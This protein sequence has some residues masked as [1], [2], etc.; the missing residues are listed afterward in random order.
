MEMF[1]EHSREEVHRVLL[2]CKGN[3]DS[4]T[5]MLLDNLGP[6]SG[7]Q[8]TSQERDCMEVCGTLVQ[9]TSK[10]IPN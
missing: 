9:Y 3:L 6:H 2:M 10:A 7:A 5:Q 1:P 4:C 8:D